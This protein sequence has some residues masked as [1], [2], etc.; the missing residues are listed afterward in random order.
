MTEFNVTANQKSMGNIEEINSIQK[1]IEFYTKNIE[2][3][4]INLRLAKE[5]HQKQYENL[6][7][8]QNSGKPTVGKDKTIEKSTQHARRTSMEFLSRESLKF[9]S[10]LE[11]IND[12]INT[13]A[14]ENKELRRKIEEL[15]KNKLTSSH[16]LEQLKQMNDQTKVKFEELYRAN[17]KNKEDVDGVISNIIF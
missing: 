7:K 14:L 1:E 4:K 13:L 2:H 9:E 6:I 16:L 10:S 15:R 17:K 8:L 5:R 11:N 12:E 3:E